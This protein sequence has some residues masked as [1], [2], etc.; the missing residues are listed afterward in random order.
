MAVKEATYLGMWWPR[1]ANLRR[2]VVGEGGAAMGAGVT[3]QGFRYHTLQ[4][5]QHSEIRAEVV[6]DAAAARVSHQWP[7]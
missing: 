1:P 7:P 4:P 2:M 5:C 3:G 6:P